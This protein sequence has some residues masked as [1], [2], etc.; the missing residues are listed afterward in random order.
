MS[1]FDIDYDIASIELMPP[2][3]RVSPNLQLVRSFFEPLRWLRAAL[4]D[5]YANGNAAPV[6]IQGKVYPKYTLVQN[7]N[8]VYSSLKNGNKD[9]P[10]NPDSW[11]PIQD[12]FI[13]MNERILYNGS[14]LMFEYAL[15]RWFFGVFRQPPLQ[16][17]IFITTQPIPVNGFI[18]SGTSPS[19]IYRSF[20]SEFVV[21]KNL[22]SFNV[23][24]TI[25]IPVAIY[26]ALSSNLIER[27]QIIRAF[28][29][30]YVA[31]GIFYSVETY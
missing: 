1:L 20:S 11:R 4:F 31:L 29:D 26:T 21:N 12:T 18:V 14:K 6:W 2:D 17:D 19:K 23:T 28:A 25:H 9:A 22:S 13:G 30:K 16:S 5:S 27:E 24:M 7:L 15:N 8:T 3:K 10:T